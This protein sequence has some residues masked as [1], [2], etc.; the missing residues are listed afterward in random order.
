MVES[1]FVFS[2]RLGQWCIWDIKKTVSFMDMSI[3]LHQACEIE[4]KV[5]EKRKRRESSIRFSRH[6]VLYFIHKDAVM[7]TNFNM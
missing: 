2:E 7:H 1:A 4:K 5:K 3:W 6:P